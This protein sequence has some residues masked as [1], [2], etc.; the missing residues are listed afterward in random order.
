LITKR[1][2][3]GKTYFL[4]FALILAATFKCALPLITIK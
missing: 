4:R 2:E 1:V 3:H